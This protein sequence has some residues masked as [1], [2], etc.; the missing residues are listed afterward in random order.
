MKTIASIVSLV[1]V[2]L[3]APTARADWKDDVFTDISKSA[4]RGVLVDAAVLNR[5]IFDDI[6]DSSPVKAPD[7]IDDGFTGE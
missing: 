6:R 2:L 5:T 1:V 4:P 7:R 3:S